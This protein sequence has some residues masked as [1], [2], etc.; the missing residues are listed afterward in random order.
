M[1]F[2][3]KEQNVF[4]NQK[5][6]SSFSFL[7]FLSRL[8][9]HNLSQSTKDTHLTHY[10]HSSLQLRD[11]VGGPVVSLD[12]VGVLPYVLPELGA[13][14]KTSIPGDG[15]D[16]PL[17]GLHP[18]YMGHSSEYMRTYVRQHSSYVLNM[19]KSSILSGLSPPIGFPLVHCTPS[20]YIN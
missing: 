2:S 20:Q 4:I 3:C 16:V 5:K 11:N 8:H 19:I 6:Q 10:I 17:T 13:F 1:Q 15:G 14:V 12:I 9:T 18:S 7:R